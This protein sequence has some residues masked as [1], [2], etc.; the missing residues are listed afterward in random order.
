[1]ERQLQRAGTAWAHD[2][3]SL[4]I[5]VDQE[6]VYRETTR[7]SKAIHDRAVKVMPGGTTRT[8]TYFD[9]YPLYI[10]RGQGCRTWDADGTDPLPILANSTPLILVPAHPH[11]PATSPT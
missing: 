11:P 7:G 9:P 3:C 2:C 8:T 4:A 1:M 6:A 10:D 5:V